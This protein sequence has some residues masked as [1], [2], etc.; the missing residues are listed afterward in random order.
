MQDTIQPKEKDAQPGKNIPLLSDKESSSQNKGATIGKN[1]TIKKNQDNKEAESRKGGRET[2]SRKFKLYSSKNEMLLSDSQESVKRRS[3]RIQERNSQEEKEQ[4]TA[5]S[6]E[7]NIE[8]K[9]EQE[10][11]DKAKTEKR[12]KKQ[13]KTTPVSSQ[14]GMVI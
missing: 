5:T 13:E 1:K 9:W 7:K 10:Q 3:C 12:S 2:Q 4:E 11:Q 8:E 6:K 14:E